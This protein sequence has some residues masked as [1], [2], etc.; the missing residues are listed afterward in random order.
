[1][2]RATEINRLIPSIYDAAVDPGLWPELLDRICE[3]VDARGAFIFDVETRIAAPRLHATY[4]TSGYDPRLVRN[5]LREHNDQE[6]QDQATF[7]AHSQ[8]TD[9]V[10]LIPDIVLAPSREALMKRANARTMAG[11]GIHHR[12]GALLNK[13]HWNSDR[14]AMQFSERAGLPSGQRLQAVH[15][16]MPHMAKAL[17]IG[18]HTSRLVNE[19][20]AILESV[21]HLRIGICIVSG[22]G[23]IVFKNVEFARQLA[24]YRAFVTTPGG[25]LLA[26]DESVRAE[27]QGLFSA[28]QNH[29]KF[30]ARPR[31]E[32]VLHPLTAD[33]FAL[34]IEV[35]PLYSPRVL[36]ERGFN[37]FVLFSLDASQAYEIDTAFMAQV[38]SLTKS[39]EAVL[40]MLA[41]GLTN[42]QISERRNRSPETVI[43]QV[44]NLLAKTMSANRTQLIRLATSFSPRLFVRD[45]IPKTGDEDEVAVR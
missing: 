18:R 20:D 10:E 7:A 34:C 24:D 8:K 37:G 44:K 23:E 15:T 2:A 14:F 45:S 42:A 16:L 29:G 32:A 3:L 41:E 39:E 17:N 35:C 1:M 25:K 31:K 26:N 12:A 19:R 5:Y 4:F 40:S 28:A 21:N 11:Y 30:G 38:F 43:S 9:G 27:L 22:S 6:L 33:G 13:D 36:N